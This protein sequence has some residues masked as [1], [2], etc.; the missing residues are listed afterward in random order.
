MKRE[1]MWFAQGHLG[2]HWL[3]QQWNPGV[4][5]PSPIFYTV[6]RNILKWILQTHIKTSAQSLKQL[7][8]K[9]I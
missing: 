8:P 9:E 3:S 5:T 4:L 6:D 2:S 7:K 1:V